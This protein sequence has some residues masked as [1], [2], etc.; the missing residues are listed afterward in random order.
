MKIRIPAYLR[1]GSTAVLLLVILG[2][3]GVWTLKGIQSE[4]NSRLADSL[5]TVLNT[6]DEGLRNWVR[7]TEIDVATLAETEELRTNVEAQLRTDRDRNALLHATALK[8]IRRLL[9]PVMKLRKL[10]EFAVIAPDGIQIASARDENVGSREIVE[11]TPGLLTKVMNGM[12]FLG[13]P[14]EPRSEEH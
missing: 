13:L 2:V 8:N 14:V 5:Q 6:A 11:S 9:L 3:A 12:S 1:L 4:V 10:A 7:Q